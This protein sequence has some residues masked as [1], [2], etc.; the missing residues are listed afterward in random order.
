MTRFIF[1]AMFAGLVGCGKD[2]CDDTAAG[3]C[4][5]RNHCL[6][7][8]PETMP[9][10]VHGILVH[11]LLYRDFEQTDVQEQFL[12]RAPHLVGVARDSLSHR[13]RLKPHHD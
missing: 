3:A 12:Y 5:W 1:V 2:D 4:D 13:L 9:P 7:H 11:E 8:Q 6:I 10:M